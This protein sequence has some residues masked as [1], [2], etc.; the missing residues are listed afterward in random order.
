MVDTAQIAR[1]FLN[2]AINARDAI[3]NGRSITSRIENAQRREP[4]LPEEPS[5][6]DYAAISGADTGSGIAD[7]VRECTFEP[8]FH[9]EADG[10]DV[11]TSVFLKSSES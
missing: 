3:R 2:V 9:N 10:M 7:D 4:A 1:A 11:R 8:F 5:A 6:G